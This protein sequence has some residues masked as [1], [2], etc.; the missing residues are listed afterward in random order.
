MARPCKR[1]TFA[2]SLAA[3]NC[4]MCGIAIATQSSSA[5]SAAAAW[6][7]MLRYSAPVAPRRAPAPAPSRNA[8]PVR[9]WPSPASAAAWSREHTWGATH[10]VDSDEARTWVYPSNMETRAYQLEIVKRALF[11]NTLVSLPTGLGKTFIAAVVMYNFYRWFPESKIVFMAPTKPL[12]AQQITACHGI[13]GIPASETAEMN[14]GVPPTRRRGLWKERRVFFCTPHILNNDLRSGV[15]DDAVRRSISLLVIDEAH[16]ATGQYAYVGAIQQLANA[17][18]CFRVL[19]L[20]ATPGSDADKV[21]DVIDNTMACALEV[22]TDE[23]PDVK[24]YTHTRLVEENIVKLGKFVGD[25]QKKYF[26]LIAPVFNWL[27]QRGLVF[28]KDV[29]GLNSYHMQLARDKTESPEFLRRGRVDPGY[30]K[31][32]IGLMQSLLMSGKLLASYGVSG[33]R[34][35]IVAMRDKAT[36]DPGKRGWA[37]FVK[38][39]PYRG[40]VR[41]LDDMIASG[42]TKHPK[43]AR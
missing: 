41:M 14:G 10:R 12:V 5:S 15:I 26:A 7:S 19:G 37:V 29:A 40:F 28:A 11:S 33:F 25:L 1:C 13:V 21:Q 4:A 17:S 3:S 9:I 16:K 39:A 6:S 43:I 32:M 18:A 42:S 20:S 8:A 24:R 38:G 36:R 22:R 30:A 27:K 31:M 23:D 34:D 35:A 2:N